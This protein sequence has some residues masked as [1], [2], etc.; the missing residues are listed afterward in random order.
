MRTEHQIA[1]LSALVDT[2]IPPDSYPGGWES[3][4]GTYL[5]HQFER[6]LA[7]FTDT[8]QEGLLALDAE[9]RKIMGAHFAALAPD[10]RRTLLI[11]VEQGNVQTDWSI[12]PILFFT[13][14]VEHCAEGFYCDPGNEGNKNSIAWVMVG[15]EVTG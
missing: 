5:F 9:A 1:V 7:G 13:T 8:Y 2:I 14:V 3:G 10:A 12:D 4:V 15:F 11:E 6:E